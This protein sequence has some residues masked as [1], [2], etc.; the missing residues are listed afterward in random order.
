V[1]RSSGAAPCVA[2]ISP[3]AQL[4]G[5]ERYLELVLQG[6]PSERIKAVVSLQE[7]PFVDALR[8]QGQDVVVVPT[9]PR[10]PGIVRSARVVRRLLRTDPPDLVHA[11]GVK[12]A[13]VAVLA[14]F[15]TCT[16]V[17]WVKHD[18]S[19]DRSL[20]RPLALFCRLV[21][22]KSQAAGRV[23][24]GRLRRRVRV[25]LYGLPPVIAD[26]D[27]GRRL[28]LETL[29]APPEA[30]V[31]AL[32]GRLYPMKGQ[33]ELLELV[34]ELVRAVPDLRVAFVGQD[35]PSEPAY[36]AGLRQRASALDLDGT[37]TF[38]G[39]LEQ[40][41]LFSAGCDVLATPSVP[42]ERGNTESFS[43]V[44]LEAMSVGT[45][46][47]G[48]AEGGLPEA[49][50]PCGLLVRTGDRRALLEALVRVVRDG[51]VRARLAAC[52]QRRASTEFGVERM[53]RELEACY[54]EAVRPSRRRSP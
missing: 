31:V 49:V 42:A 33:H 27:A 52:G 54:L 23:F 22:A 45:P 50:G 10:L 20:A 46:V 40:A 37:V 21:V 1:S 18:L 51:E 3:Y 29:A 26:R 41:P 8:A 35:D 7:G 36:A 47:V 5:S 6:L 17:V 48:Y 53:L 19:F 24:K 30:R 38:V 2:F 11:N 4:A 32:I 16:P 14:T 39:R 9:S 34:P 28:V 13:L 25:V 15:G 12:A 44:A 43:L